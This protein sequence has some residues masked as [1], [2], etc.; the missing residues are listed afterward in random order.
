MG[1]NRNSHRHDAYKGRGNQHGKYEER[2]NNV[3]QPDPPACVTEIDRINYLGKIIRHQRYIG[4]FY[5]GIGPGCA[6]GN[7]HQALVSAGE[8]LMPS[9]TMATAPYASSS[10]S[11]ILSS[12]LKSALTTSMP[13]SLAMALAV[14]SLSP[15]TLMTL[16][17][18][19]WRNLDVLVEQLAGVP[20][21]ADF[22]DLQGMPRESFFCQH[23]R[24]IVCVQNEEALFACLLLGGRDGLVK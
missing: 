11:M 10:S 6:H 18:I 3:L 2:K 13:S 4:G 22:D 14:I 5:G 9:P 16:T 21:V 20:G 8:S 23:R 1:N 15:V 24:H 19:L 17:P 7:P 12:G